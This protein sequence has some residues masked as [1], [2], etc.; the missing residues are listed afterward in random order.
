MQQLTALF[1]LLLSAL[2]LAA[3]RLPFT[4]VNANNLTTETQKTAGSDNALDLVW[5]I[6]VEFWQVALA[7]NA[8][9]TP[10][11]IDDIVDTLRPYSL[12]A[13]VQADISTF[14]AF[15]FFDE[16]KV[17]SGLRVVYTPEHGSSV[18]IPLDEL[19]DP[20]VTLL[21]N[22]MSPV[23]TAAMG[24]LGENFFF[25]PLPDMDDTGQRII[26]PYERGSLAITLTARD[27]IHRP[28]YLIEFPL[29]ALHQPRLCPNGKP[30]HVSWA[31]CPW[32]GKKLKR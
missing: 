27:G 14:G 17:S 6:P 29:D 26:S 3:E 23:L 25:F 11:Q 4:E 28:P 21:L 32:S 7:N 30:A 5:W 16:V 19:I 12:L 8:A 10:A 24:N 18:N 22:Q 13:V 31:Y 2:G 15:D 1:L 20:D 9:V